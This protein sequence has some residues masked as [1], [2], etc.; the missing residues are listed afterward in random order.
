MTKERDASPRDDKHILK[1]KVALKPILGE[2]HNS[3]WKTYH[4]LQRQEDDENEEENY[5]KFS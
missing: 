2:P 1:N 3:F 4:K 5:L